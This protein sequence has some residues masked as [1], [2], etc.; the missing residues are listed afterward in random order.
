MIVRTVVDLL[1]AAKGKCFLNFLT[2]PV[3]LVGDNESRDNPFKKK[4]VLVVVTSIFEQIQTLKVKD[5][6]ADKDKAD[7]KP[8][9]W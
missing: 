9:A 8:V 6:K 3:E 7:G 1:K 4:K 5:N 2:L